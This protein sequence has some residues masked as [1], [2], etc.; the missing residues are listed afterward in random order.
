MIVSFLFSIK[1]PTKICKRFFLCATIK[2]SKN[3]KDSFLGMWNEIL[4]NRKQ[5]LLIGKKGLYNPLVINSCKR[6][7]QIILIACNN[8][9]FPM[10]ADF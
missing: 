7:A 2:I 9:S 3:Q 1:L 10:K 6:V 5:I 4:L 8:C